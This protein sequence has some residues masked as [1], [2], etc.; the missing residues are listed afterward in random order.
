MK[1][2]LRNKYTGLSPR[3]I[4]SIT[5]FSDGIPG[6]AERFIEDDNF[7]EIRDTIIEVL[8]SINNKKPREFSKYEDFFVKYKN[9]WQETL[10]WILSYIRDILIYKDT[11]IEELIVNMDKLDKIKDAASLFSFNKLNDIIE[12]VNKTRQK[13]ERNVNTSLTFNNMLLKFLDI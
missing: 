6:R 9:E 1:V 4:K 2:F 13:L 12:I 8:L 7:K 10:T 3:E 11:G 5:A